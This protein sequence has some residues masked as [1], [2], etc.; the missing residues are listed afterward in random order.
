MYI[1]WMLYT[2]VLDLT[3]LPF[4]LSN[5][6]KGDE[7]TSYDWPSSMVTATPSCK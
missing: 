5:A 3:V 4:T 6:F 1:M 7:G 2:C